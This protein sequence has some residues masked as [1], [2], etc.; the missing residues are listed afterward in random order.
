MKFKKIALLAVVGVSVLTVAS[1]GI[2]EE[3]YKK[4]AYTYNTYL[5]VSP[6]DWNELTYQDANDTNIMSYLG[7]SFFTYDFK[8][9][10]EG[11]IIDGEFT[12]NYDAATKLEDVTEDYAGQYAVPEK[13]TSKYAYKITLREDL[14]WH[15]GT[16]I[17][18]EDFVYTMKEQLNPDFKNYRADSFYNSGTVIHNARDYVLQGSTVTNDNADTEYI[19]AVT[20]LVKGA[21]GKY[22]T[23]DGKWVA[24]AIAAP[25]SW[26]NGNSLAD[27]VGAYG[28]QYFDVAAYE[29]VA[30]LADENGYVAV[31]DESIKLMGE[32]LESEGS[33]IWGET[34]ENI[35]CYLHYEYTYPEMAWEEV[36]F[37]TG[38]TDYEI[39]MV[40]DKQLEL[41]KEDGSLSYQAAYN[42][43]SL[44]LVKKDLYEACKVAPSESNNLWT[45][46]Y[47]TS[48]ETTAS[49]GPY[50]LDTFQAGKSYS[51]VKND[52]WYGYSTDLYKDKYQTT[53]IQCE[54][55][56]EYN[57]A[58]QKFMAGEL[59]SIGVDVSVATDY[60]NSGQAV[61]SGDDYVGSLQLQSNV[62]AL[63]A[64]QTAGY[65]KTILAETE[66]RKALSLAIDRVEYNNTCTTASL[67]GF[68]IFNSYHYY[69]VENGK[70]YRNSDDAK[71][72]IC[73]VYGVDVSK[74]ESLDKAYA[75]VT[76]F[77]LE[78]ARQLLETAYQASL[79]KSNGIKATDKV[80]LTFGTS[81]INE[82]TQR[83][84]DFITAEWVELTKGTSLEGRFE[85][86]LK[87]YDKAWANEFRAGS[88]DVCTGG[89]SGA[90]WDPG[91]FL[92]AYLDEGYM[93]S[94]AWDTKGEAKL[95]FK[96]EGVMEEAET[97][98][99]Y[100]WYNCLNGIAG[101]DYDWSIGNLEDSKRLTLI[102]AL[103]KEIL[104]VYYTVPIQYYYSCSLI[105]YQIEYVTRKENTFMGFGG[106]RYMTYE[107][108]DYEWAKFIKKEYKNDLTEVYKQAADE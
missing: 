63:E 48:L 62:T 24:L 65:N 28:A 75:A 100:D 89:W 72:T 83:A 44:P 91:Y 47:N 107:Y 90:A 76:G 35:V 73:E 66:F 32:F 30:A 82:S 41:L 10:S 81:A 18:A 3:K 26:C 57:T 34:A 37:F 74:Y 99:L 94:Q 69:D 67:P 14:K 6:S 97:K 22:T 11:N 5:S 106:M 55:I 21:D 4:G 95:T 84:F 59:D 8:F 20:D 87:A 15:D 105:S 70:A 1:C 36:G 43:S 58:F 46:T 52:N 93:Y 38:D 71:K 102:A 85:T 29:K 64:R 13:A 25:S 56:A 92:L 23:K 53:N 96:M 12:T 45:T 17:T 77:D 60:K 42:M 50:M 16:A 54:I 19:S 86:E 33:K 68:G 79:K 7:S 98:S 27:Y 31:T 40:L 88:Y 2:D 80:K 104:S 103:E 49:W 78:Q 51:L 101:A 108:D 61:R 9:D 39:V